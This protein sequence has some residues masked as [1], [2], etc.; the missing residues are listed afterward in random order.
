MTSDRSGG[1]RLRYER[2]ILLSALL[3][4]VPPLALA[5]ILLWRGDF[6]PWTQW[7]LT[8]LTVGAWI[9]FAIVLREHV[10]RSLQ[11]ISNMLAALREGDFSLRVSGANPDDAMGLLLLEL[12]TLGEDLRGQRLSAFEATA[13]LRRVMEE[14][15]VAVLAFDGSHELRLAN[16]SGAALLGRPAEQV[17]GRSAAELGLGD[18][19]SGEAPRVL[20]LEFRG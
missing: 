20:D 8:V 19:L 17:L 11:T 14:I 6:V 7:T 9:A 10:V 4:G 13:L 3:T 5:L 12:N 16:R 1:R 2:R 18:C 15:D